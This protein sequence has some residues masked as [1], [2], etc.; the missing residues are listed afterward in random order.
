MI[1]KANKGKIGG[2]HDKVK[3]P[4]NIAKKIMEWIDK[5]IV[6]YPLVLDASMGEGAFYFNFNNRYHRDWCEIDKGRDFF[7]YLGKVDWI[8]TNPPYSIFDAFL[9][10][11]F[12]ISDNVVFLC[13]LSKIVSSMGRIR[14]YKKYGGIPKI[15][16]I[17]AS[18]CGFP[19]GFPC[20]AVWF[21]KGY[22]GGTEIDID[23]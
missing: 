1:V 21:K 23:E 5:E 16:I 12:E 4:D 18:K 8:I 13:P 19:F 14:K 22:N 15:L 17:S 7:Q 20:C 11:S 10:H 6:G 2:V 3:T 9:E